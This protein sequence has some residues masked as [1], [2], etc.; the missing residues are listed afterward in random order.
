[1]RRWME[2]ERIFGSMGIGF[3]SGKMEAGWLVGSALRTRE[4]AVAWGWDGWDII[5]DY[6][7]WYSYKY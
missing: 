3:G 5:L 6:R 7:V 1:M 2:D 4:V